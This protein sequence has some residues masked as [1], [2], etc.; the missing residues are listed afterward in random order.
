MIIEERLELLPKLLALVNESAT[1]NCE[2]LFSHK[3]EENLKPKT[4][5][6]EGFGTSSG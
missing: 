2:G 6:E 5:M 3:V 1:P 4:Q